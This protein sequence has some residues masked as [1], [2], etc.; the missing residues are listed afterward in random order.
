MKDTQNQKDYR[1]LGIK[2]V[3]VCD[4][5]LPIF[6]SDKKNGKQ[7]VVAKI[8]MST[9]LPANIRGTHMSRF[10]EAIYEYKSRSFNIDILEAILNQIKQE[11][12]TTE[13]NIQIV[14]T[15]FIKKI[16]PISRKEFLMD[17]RC[18]I[19]GRIIKSGKILKELEVRVPVSSLCPC[20]KKISKRGAH[21]QRG[22]IIINV[23][24]LD[25]IWLEDLIEIAEKEASGILYPILKRPDEKYVTEKMFDNAKFVE[26]I[27]RDVAL[28]L[29]KDK[30]IINFSVKCTNY[31][32]VHNHNAYAKITKQK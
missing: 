17:Y 14:F 15:Y 31:E 5:F 25:F 30:R 2:E 23:I 18:K 22:L 28:S 3:G 29:N 16:A 19:A 1:M 24:T 4:I 6:V 7:Q 9:N 20:S 11:L 27:V 10:L 13:A 26:D 21:N 8:K 32:S 12:K